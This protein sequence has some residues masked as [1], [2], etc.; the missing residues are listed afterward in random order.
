M[1]QLT[2]LDWNGIINQTERRERDSDN[3]RMTAMT[4]TTSHQIERRWTA[5]TKAISLKT[6]ATTV[7]ESAAV[8]AVDSVTATFQ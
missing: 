7:T 4:T 5:V 3:S 2:E 8:V 6:T 1:N